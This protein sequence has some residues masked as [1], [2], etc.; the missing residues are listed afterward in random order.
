MRGLLVFFIGASPLDSYYFDHVWFLNTYLF[1][2]SFNKFLELQVVLSLLCMYEI[3]SDKVQDL[4]ELCK[5]DDPSW[6]R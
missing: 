3:N 5:F 6:L 2:K 1:R 4:F